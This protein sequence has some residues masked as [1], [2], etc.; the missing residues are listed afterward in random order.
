MSGDEEDNYEE[1]NDDNDDSGSSN[2][3]SLDGEVEAPN[4]YVFPGYMAC[5]AWGPFAEPIE[6]LLLF[7]N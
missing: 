1:D 4:S 5:V 3:D 2:E 7:I 6:I